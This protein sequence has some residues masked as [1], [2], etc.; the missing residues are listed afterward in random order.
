M[1]KVKNV[2]PD[3]EN[4]KKAEKATE[5]KKKANLKAKIAGKQANFKLGH[6][7]KPKDGE[8]PKEGEKPKPQTKVEMRTQQKKLKMERRK[9][10]DV[11]GVFDLS[12]QAKKV[13]EEV[14]RED[15]PK[16]KQVC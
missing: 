16:D 11:T 15:C 14:R 4:A 5:P 1:Q 8:K 7:A 12:V 2:K 6:K 13:W 3:K 9:K 10:R